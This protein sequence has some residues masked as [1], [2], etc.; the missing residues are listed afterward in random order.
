[1]ARKLR[2]TFERWSHTQ[3]VWFYKRLS[4]IFDGVTSKLLEVDLFEAG[5]VKQITSRE[6]LLSSLATFT[7]KPVQFFA[8]LSN[9]LGKTSSRLHL[10]L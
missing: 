3:G 7:V 10:A 9:N 1:M 5:Q 8:I 2:S 6:A 4:T